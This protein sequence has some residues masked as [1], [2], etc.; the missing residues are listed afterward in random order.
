V[1]SIAE[2]I[3]NERARSWQARAAVLCLA[4]AFAVVPG[5]S[6]EVTL[7][8]NESQGRQLALGVD[9]I[10]AWYRSDGAWFGESESFLGADVDRWADF[11]VEPTLSFETRSGNGTLFAA[12]SGVYTSTVGDDAAGSTAGLEDTVSLTLE[13]AHVGWRAQDLFAALEGDVFSIAVGRLDYGIG[14][15]LLVDDGGADGGERGG[16]YLGMRK[17]FARSLLASLDSDTWLF[18]IFHLEN[19]PRAG[20]TR[21]EANGANVEYRFAEAAIGTSYLRVDTDDPAADSLDVYSARASWRFAPGLELAGEYADEHSDQIGAEGYY[22]EIGYAPKSR[23]GSPRLIFRHA[24]FS[25]DDPATALDERFRE[26]AYGSTDWTSWYQGEVTGEYALGL[27]NLKSDLA[28]LTLTPT[29]GVTLDA[30]YYRFTLDQPASFGAASDDWGDELNLV[31]E[32][33]ADER[34]TVTG[35]LAYLRPGEAAEE[36]VGG[37]D[38]WLH[39]MLLVSFSW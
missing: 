18:E 22:A 7:V 13:Q 4:A 14:T 2:I 34:V 11:G 10:G 36:I 32:W 27:G 31:V 39:A 35:V 28:R 26:I 16:W 12:L 17:A 20:D 9:A 30:M 15:G 5:A 33:A 29:D 21:G 37:R 8:D 3:D 19:Q 6:A 25:G 38:D 24:R 23:A 1:G